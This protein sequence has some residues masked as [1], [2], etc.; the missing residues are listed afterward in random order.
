MLFR[1]RDS[2]LSIAQNYG[3]VPAGY[4]Q[5]TV[6]VTFSN[7]SA[8]AV[9][10][11]VGTV[12]TGTVSSGDIVQTVYFTTNAEAVLDAQVDE[13]PG[14]DTVS[15]SEGR[16]VL[17]VSDN[18]NTYG[19]LIGTSTGLPSMTF[20]LGETP[21]VDNS[22]ELYVQDGDIYSKWTQVQHILDY[23][24]TDFVYSTFLNEDNTVTITFGDG[25]IGR[26]HV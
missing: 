4:R 21:V 20:Q 23:G 13:I 16:S 7:T 11:P 17:L 6:D 25:E 24:P 22:V 1:S 5:A 2:I 26:A 10:I 19:E 8:S 14:T 15:A 9:T 12:L 18:V 3:Y